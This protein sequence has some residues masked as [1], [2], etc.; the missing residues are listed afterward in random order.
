M[1]FADPT[2]F[3]TTCRIRV[4]FFARVSVGTTPSVLCHS[5]NK[6]LSRGQ[7]K[8]TS[9]D[10]LVE[11]TDCTCTENWSRPDDRFPLQLQFPLLLMIRYPFSF[12]SQPAGRVAGEG[13]RPSPSGTATETDRLWEEHAGLP[14][15][16]R[17]HSQVGRL[18]CL[19]C[20]TGFKG[21]L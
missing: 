15:L 4:F 12:Y 18:L 17:C 6:M 14:T 9:E 2:S 1:K 10:F 21:C 16:P 20:F 11:D 3:L 19:A 5:V 8:D 13:N 7:P